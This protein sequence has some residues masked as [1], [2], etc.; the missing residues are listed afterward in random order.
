MIKCLKFEYGCWDT[1]STVK[2]RSL[3]T[4]HLPDKI[5]SNFSDDI[6][7][8]LSK[9]TIDRYN[10]LEIPHSRVYLLHGPP[11]TG[12][13]S[14]I[15]AIASKYNMS[16]GSFAVD[17][18]TSDH[19]LKTGIKRLPKK[20]ILVIEDIDS[21]FTDRKT[22]NS[23]LTYSGVLNAIDG[24]N[25]LSEKIIFITTNYLKD[26]DS[27]L[28]RRVDYFVKFDFCTKDQVKSIFER[29]SPELE[30]EKVWKVCRNLK[31]TPSILQK[32]LIR[33]LPLEDL[34][35]FARGDHGLENLP[36]MYT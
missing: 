12:K 31:L 33:E 18:K 36:E 22:T 6:E 9:E 21:F 7:K 16:I 30:F 10:R 15:Q 34:E 20:T 14:L 23:E 26:I 28:K 24:V 2:K 19:H 35:E 13:T 8:F 25:R 29:F 27:A 32:F 3:S 11:G 1:E 4:I 17:G 5:F